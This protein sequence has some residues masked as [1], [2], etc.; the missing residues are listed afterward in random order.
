MPEFGMREARKT[1]AR[2]IERA[3]YGE[4][5]VIT[6]DDVPVARLEPIR[7]SASA[8]AQSTVDEAFVSADQ[9]ELPGIEDAVSADQDELPGIEHELSATDDAG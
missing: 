3:Q 4:E 5:I 9:D 6:K 7:R 8:A 1:L 2:L